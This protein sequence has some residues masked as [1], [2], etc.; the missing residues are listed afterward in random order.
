MNKINEQKQVI[1]K[2]VSHL[3]KMGNDIYYISTNDL[4]HEIKR[5][6]NEKNIL[7]KDDIELVSNLGTNEIKSL[8]T[9]SSSCC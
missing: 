6:I 2:I 1:T 7:S 4:C 9:C 8:L 5:E 3:S